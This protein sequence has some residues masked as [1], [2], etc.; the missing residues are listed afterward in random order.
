MMSPSPVMPVPPWVGFVTIL[1]CCT[2]ATLDTSK[3]SSPPGASRAGPTS[4]PLP[5]KSG[6]E[7]LAAALDRVLVAAAS[8]SPHRGRGRGTAGRVV[9][10]RGGPVREDIPGVLARPPGKAVCRDPLRRRATIVAPQA[11]GGVA[12]RRLVLLR[13]GPLG[14]DVATVL[15]ASPGESVGRTSLCEHV[16]WVVAAQEGRG[17]AGRAAEA[18][19][20]RGLGRAATQ[21]DARGAARGL[22]EPRRRVWRL[23]GCLTLLPMLGEDGP[24]IVD[25]Q[26]DSGRAPHL[27]AHRKGLLGVR[28]V[29]APKAEGDGR[30]A[31]RSLLEPWSRAWSLDVHRLLRPP[32][33]EHLI[34]ASRPQDNGC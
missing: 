3:F 19:A 1:S 33:V 11:D 5:A 2:A 17:A 32:L 9:E 13:G 4:A 7:A 20:G 30:V 10:P 22:R 6:A 15:V 16:V 31:A 29:G 24:R 26:D 18:R 28:C 21:Q 27:P 12:T 25:A 34:G 23:D 8:G 14:E